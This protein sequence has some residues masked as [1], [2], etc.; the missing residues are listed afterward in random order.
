MAET[1]TETET[2]TKT[3]SASA[4]E[5]V[6]ATQTGSDSEAV[7]SHGKET[8]CLKAESVGGAEGGS[9]EFAALVGRVEGDAGVVGVVLSGSRAREGTATEYSDY[10]VLLVV[11][12]EVG[13]RLDGEARRDARLDVSTMAL[14]EFR[15]HALAGSGAEWNR[16]AFRGAKVLKDTAD[17]LIAGLVAEKGRLAEAEAGQLAPGVLDAFLNS[18]YRCLKNDRDG[19]EVGAR[20]DGAEAIPHY[21]TYVFA[22]HGRVRPYNKYLAWELERYPLSRPERGR[23]ELLSRLV[24]VYFDDVA[25]VVRELFRELEPHAR[26]AG[27]GGV[28]DAW[29]NDLVFMR[30]GA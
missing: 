26:A 12:D 29:G 25:Q 13:E 28:L 20:M 23:D 15:T 4:R 3:E 1:E 17:G 18:V 7:A 6:S 9:G 22:L 2:D 8:F 14:G 27:H 21:L 16:Y 19:N 24:R 30:G 5:T 11:G 10:D